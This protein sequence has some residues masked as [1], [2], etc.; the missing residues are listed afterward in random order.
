[1]RIVLFDKSCIRGLKLNEKGLPN[2]QQ[3]NENSICGC[4]SEL[5][6]KRRVDLRNKNAIRKKCPYFSQL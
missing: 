4:I 1:M 5:H 6:S 3:G 2:A